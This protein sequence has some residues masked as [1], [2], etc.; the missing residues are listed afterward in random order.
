MESKTDL[1]TLIVEKIDKYTKKIFALS[2]PT[3]YDPPLPKGSG[4]LTDK[5]P[6]L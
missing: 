1:Y 2:I 5:T 4:F 6:N 3:H